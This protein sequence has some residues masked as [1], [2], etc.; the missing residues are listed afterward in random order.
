MNRSGLLLLLF[1]GTAAE[2]QEDLNDTW[3][4]YH[5]ANGYNVRADL[6]RTRRN[7]DRYRFGKELAPDTDA[8]DGDLV[9][10]AS[11]AATTTR[12]SIASATPRASP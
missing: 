8:F 1:A 12:S 4:H 6:A 10:Q 2:A 7:M 11:S 5:L 9:F 3:M